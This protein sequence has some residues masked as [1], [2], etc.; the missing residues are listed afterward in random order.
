[1]KWY[2]LPQNYCNV[3]Q[4]LL[5]QRQQ[6]QTIFIAKVKPLNMETSLG[7]SEHLFKRQL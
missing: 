2:L 7:V 1:M 4:M 6:Q 3:Y 5:R